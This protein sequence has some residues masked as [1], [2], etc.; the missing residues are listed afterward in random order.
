MSHQRTLVAVTPPAS[1]DLAQS[2][3]FCRRIARSRA[4]NFYYSF[5]LLPPEQKSAMCAVYAFMRFCD[6]ISEGEGASLEAIE[7]WR[8]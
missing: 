2:Y 4:R 3:D 7:R 8:S 6:D 1:I 5:V